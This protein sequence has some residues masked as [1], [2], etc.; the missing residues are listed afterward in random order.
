MLRPD[1]C[2]PRRAARG[3]K[4]RPKGLP[5]GAPGVAKRLQNLMD[6]HDLWF[7]SK[8]RWQQETRPGRRAPGGP[9]GADGD[10]WPADL[11]ALMGPRGP[12]VG[13]RW[14]P[15]WGLGAAKRLQNPMDFDD[16]W[17]GSK[18]RWHRATRPTGRATRGLLS[19][20]GR[21]VPH[22]ES[23]TPRDS[24]RGDSCDPPKEDHITF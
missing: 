9:Q 10:L 3:Q 24:P 12:Q 4:W 20:V 14:R 19:V 23:S 2:H 5:R 11:G 13:P 7:G 21:S 15:S 6:F 8:S 16:F 18:S 22:R 17:F 1:R